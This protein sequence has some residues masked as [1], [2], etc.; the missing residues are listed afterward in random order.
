MYLAFRVKLFGEYITKLPDYELSRHEDIPLPESS[1]EPYH[2]DDNVEAKLFI[3]GQNIQGAM[4]P[5]TTEYNTQSQMTSSSERDLILDQY[6]VMA[7]NLA[8]GSPDEC[9]HDDFELVSDEDQIVCLRSPSLVDND[10]LESRQSMIKRLSSRTIQTALDQDIQQKTIDVP[11]RGQQKSRWIFSASIQLSLKQESEREGEMVDGLP[12]LDADMQ[13]QKL[14][15]D[16][17]A[18]NAI[19]EEGVEVVPYL[20]CEE[21]ESNKDDHTDRVSVLYLK[22]SNKTM[23]DID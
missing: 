17:V 2:G 4:I 11:Q 21:N 6:K 18:N 22:G 7:A 15:E 19:E 14:I 16:H 1:A 3:P 9:L 5:S 8:I 20:E 23:R 10:S 13:G 12:L